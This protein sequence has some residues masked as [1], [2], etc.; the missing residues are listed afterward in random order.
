[1][2]VVCADLYKMKVELHILTQTSMKE[3]FL[4]IFSPNKGNFRDCCRSISNKTRIETLLVLKSYCPVRVAEVYP[5]KQGL[6]PPMILFYK[7]GRFVAEVY[8]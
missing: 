5:I 2:L 3:E 1:V 4:M 7:E 8:Q 6:K